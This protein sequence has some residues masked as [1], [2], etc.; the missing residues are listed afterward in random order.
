M[1]L[2]GSCSEDTVS[3]QTKTFLLSCWHLSVGIAPL[4]IL[5]ED[6]LPGSGPLQA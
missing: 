1:G 3:R 2:S 4:K 5:R 6:I